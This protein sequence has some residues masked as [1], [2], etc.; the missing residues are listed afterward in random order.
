MFAPC[1]LIKIDL[2]FSG[3]YC[4]YRGYY[5]GGESEHL[6]NVGQFYQT[7]WRNIL[8]VSHLHTH[9]PEIEISLNEVCLWESCDLNFEIS[10][11]V[12]TIVPTIV[13]L[14]YMSFRVL[15]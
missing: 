6:R 8:E 15:I 9:R 10:V 3:A 13:I 4:L 1:N 7:T 2:R 11:Y 12:N 14:Y 5:G